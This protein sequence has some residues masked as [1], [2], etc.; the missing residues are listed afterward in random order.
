MPRKKAAPLVLGMLTDDIPNAASVYMTVNSSHYE[1]RINMLEST[2]MR[3]QGK[4]EAIDDNYHKLDKSLDLAIIEMRSEVKEVRTEVRAVRHDVKTLLSRFD[5]YEHLEGRVVT[6]EDANK[7][8]KWFLNLIPNTLNFLQKYWAV[9][10]FLIAVCFTFDVSVEV[11]NP[12]LLEFIKSK[13][14]L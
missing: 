12:H 5:I 11:Q 13:V 3:H 1:N 14:H 2:L 10:T 9:I 4:F 6:L 7:K 8:R